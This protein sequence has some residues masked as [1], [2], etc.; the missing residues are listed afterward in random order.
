[1]VAVAAETGLDVIPRWAAITDIL[2]GRSGLI[3]FSV[4]T[5]AIIGSRE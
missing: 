3:F 4:A 2:S 1:M 5:S